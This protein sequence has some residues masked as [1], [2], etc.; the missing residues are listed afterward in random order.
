MRDPHPRFVERRGQLL[1]VTRSIVAREFRSGFWV[2]DD[3]KRIHEMVTERAAKIGE[4]V[5]I[6]RFARFVVGEGIEKK[7]DDLAAEVAK[8]LG[9]AQS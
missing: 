5:S 7:K 3:K 8:T 1:D 9:T 4:K 6:R 2:K